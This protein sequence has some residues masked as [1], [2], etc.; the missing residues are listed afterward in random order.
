[1]GG[2]RASA[3]C[4]SAAVAAREKGWSDVE[5]GYLERMGVYG[6]VAREY[7]EATRA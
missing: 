3:S 1:M 2:T 7:P 4:T 6:E 5:R